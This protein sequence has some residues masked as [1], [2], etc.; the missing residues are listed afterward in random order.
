[1]DSFAE[2]NHLLSELH[3]VKKITIVILN[4]DGILV[5]DIFLVIDAQGPLEER[6]D[7]S[8]AGELELAL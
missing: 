4:R 7:G 3:L 8:V 2:A 1:V 5:R 6:A